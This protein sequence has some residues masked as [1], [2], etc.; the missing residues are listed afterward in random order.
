MAWQAKL[1]AVST[2]YMYYLYDYLLSF[3][4][5]FCCNDHRRIKQ[6]RHIYYSIIIIFYYVYERRGTIQIQNVQFKCLKCLCFKCLST[7]VS[8]EKRVRLSCKA[9]VL[10][11]VCLP[12]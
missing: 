10:H 8:T 4:Y 9:E 11:G 2:F 3:A 7:A 5:W 6:S 1:Q 12:F